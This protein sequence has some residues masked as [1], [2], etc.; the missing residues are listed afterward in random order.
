VS[1]SA[2]SIF[3]SSPY[4]VS[5]SERKGKR[6]LMKPTFVALIIG[7]GNVPEASVALKYEVHCIRHRFLQQLRETHRRVYPSGFNCLLAM[8][9]E[10]VT[11]EAETPRDSAARSRQKE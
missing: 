6:L 2:T 7:P 1:L 4:G 3:S 11:T 9:R 8:S 5:K 10:V